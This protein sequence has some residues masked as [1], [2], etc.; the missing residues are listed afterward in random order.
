[1]LELICV[2]IKIFVYRFFKQN[3]YLSAIDHFL[4]AY[5]C[6]QYS[7]ED[8]C[9]AIAKAE[10][11]LGATYHQILKQDP[12]TTEPKL[13]QHAIMFLNASYQHRKML[14]GMENEPNK[15]MHASAM[16]KIGKRLKDLGEL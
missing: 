13:K 5:K 3:K 9:V 4:T 12:K 10:Y 15:T 2:I 1:M 16:E 11:N 8:P 7:L 14:K 6:A